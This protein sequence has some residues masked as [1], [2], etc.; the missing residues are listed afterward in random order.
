MRV[1]FN[2]EKEKNIQGSTKM[3]QG[4]KFYNDLRIVTYIFILKKIK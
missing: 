3:W 1:E 4:N 2:K